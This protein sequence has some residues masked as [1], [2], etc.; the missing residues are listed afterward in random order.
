MINFEIFAPTIVELI[1]EAEELLDNGPD[2]H[3]WVVNE[4][5]KVAP[6]PR[7]I[8]RPVRRA[9]MAWLVELIFQA[10]IKGLNKLAEAITKK[11]EGKPPVD[12]GTP[13]N[14]EHVLDQGAR[15]VAKAIKAGE[16][17]TRLDAL[18]DLEGRV[19]ARKAVLTA[20]DA[21]R[22]VLAG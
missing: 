5:L 8:P 18:A 4:A 11:A 15:K 6:L 19:K 13:V 12:P 3:R 14:L 10:A 17:D 1:H 2:K 22:A 21:R 16:H 9:V 20:V 7:Y